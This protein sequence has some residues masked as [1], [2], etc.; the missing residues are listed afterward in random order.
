MTTRQK[1]NDLEQAIAA[2]RRLLASLEHKLQELTRKSNGT[3]LA[4][5]R[6]AVLERNG[7]VIRQQLDNLEAKLS[8]SVSQAQLGHLRHEVEQVNTAMQS[9]ARDLREQVA[10]LDHRVDGIDAIIRQLRNDLALSI[11]WE[12]SGVELEHDAR[13]AVDTPWGTAIALGIV[14]GL[15]CAFALNLWIAEDWNGAKDFWCSL[16]VGIATLC[17]TA[18]FERFRLDLNL[19]GRLVLPRREVQQDQVS[20][21]T[22]IPA[23]NVPSNEEVNAGRY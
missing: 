4:N 17:L 3:T 11:D 19:R 22:F 13:I 23:V 2:H 20:Q 10:T 12:R 15:L 1:I 8:L 5:Q 9:H 14:A 21:T 6:V 7:T 16:I 18:S